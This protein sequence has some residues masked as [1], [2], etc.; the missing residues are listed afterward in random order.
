MDGKLEW[1]ARKYYISQGCNDLKYILTVPKR[2][3]NK[4]REYLY[5]EIG[6]RALSVAARRA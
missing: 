1:H 5:V 6:S 3:K 4:R 2:Q